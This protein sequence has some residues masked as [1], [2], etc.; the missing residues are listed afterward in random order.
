MSNSLLAIL[1]F[2]GVFQALTF[3]AILLKKSRSNQPGTILAILLLLL[4][5]KL[6]EGALLNSG[7]YK[8]FPHI[9]DLIPGAALIM[10]PLIYAY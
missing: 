3:G 2:A 5:Y 4:A 1:Y 6:F 9:L 7:L 10:G 8:V